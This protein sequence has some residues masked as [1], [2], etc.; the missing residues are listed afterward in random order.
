[1]SLRLALNSW[2]S[3]LYLP[4]PGL[5]VCPSMS[6]HA[7][8]LMGPVLWARVVFS[9][10]GTSAQKVSDLGFGGKKPTYQANAENSGLS[11]GQL[12]FSSLILFFLISM[13]L[14]K[15]KQDKR[16]IN[17]VSQCLRGYRTHSRHGWKLVPKFWQDLAP[18]LRGGRSLKVFLFQTVSC[19]LGT[20]VLAENC[21]TSSSQCIHASW[22]DMSFFIGPMCTQAQRP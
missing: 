15:H 7:W 6:D 22:K 3:G 1:M 2:S 4:S 10:S 18:S 11:H 8:I 12:L 19:T 21:I 16:F 9:S 5:H 20:R 14:L 13:I 17:Q